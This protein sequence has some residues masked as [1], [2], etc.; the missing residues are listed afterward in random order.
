MAATHPVLLLFCEAMSF[1]NYAIHLYALYSL[2]VIQLLYQFYF[3]FNFDLLFLSF[4]PV[5]HVISGYIYLTFNIR[6]F[7][8]LKYLLI[9]FEFEFGL[10]YLDKLH[11]LWLVP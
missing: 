6:I 11:L 3:I 9:E 5:P 4:I 7:H 1:Y 2:S 8:V 10:N